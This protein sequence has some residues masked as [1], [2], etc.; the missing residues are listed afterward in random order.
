MWHPTRK[1]E[2]IKRTKLKEISVEDKKVFK[3]SL[4]EIKEY[5]KEFK[6]NYIDNGELD[7]IFEGIKLSQLSRFYSILEDRNFHKDSNY[8]RAFLDKQIERAQVSGEDSDVG[9]AKKFFE[10]YRNNFLTN[11]PEE[12]DHEKNKIYLD[13]FKSYFRFKI[14]KERIEQ[15]GGK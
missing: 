8:I 6:E 15:E 4:A 3:L 9:R 7:R 10:Y 13:L 14:G 12:L 2:E 11:N 1:K 5:K